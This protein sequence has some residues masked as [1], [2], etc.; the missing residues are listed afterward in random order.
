M[1]TH[2]F[3]GPQL[4]NHND[5]WENVQDLNDIEQAN[6]DEGWAP[7]PPLLP[8]VAAA[9]NL[10]NGWPTWPQQGEVVDQNEL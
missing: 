2:P 8:N 9:A 6:V 7:P 1:E 3:L 10:E 4:E 5:Y